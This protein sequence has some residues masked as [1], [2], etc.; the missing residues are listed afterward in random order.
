VA[1]FGGHAFG[2]VRRVILVNAF[3]RLEVPARIGVP[4]RL[5]ILVLAAAMDVRRIGWSPSG[6]LDASSSSGWVRT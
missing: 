6:P 5:E 2:A 1:G 3:A 4:A